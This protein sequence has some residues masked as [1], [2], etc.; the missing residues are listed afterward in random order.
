MGSEELEKREA[1]GDAVRQQKQQHVRSA[2]C[3]VALTIQYGVQPL[4]SKRFTGKQVI[5]T[6][7]VLT[8]EMVKVYDR[9]HLLEGCTCVL[10]APSVECSSIYLHGS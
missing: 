6:S 2:M 4:I 5:M 1:V 3:M 10:A 8:C 9:C 7:A